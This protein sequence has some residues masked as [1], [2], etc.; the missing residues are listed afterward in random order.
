MFNWFI[1]KRDAW[2]LVKAIE[3]NIRGTQSYD[4][5]KKENYLYIYMK[6]KVV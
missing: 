5:E 6:Q 2:V 3:I 1:K 4:R